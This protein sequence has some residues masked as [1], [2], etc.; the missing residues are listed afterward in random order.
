MNRKIYIG[1]ENIISPL[2]ESAESTFSSMKE[3][4]TAVRINKNRGFNNEDL[5]LSTFSKP[6]TF[7]E[8]LLQCC[9][10]FKDLLSSPTTLLVI[11]TTKGDLNHH[12]KAILT[13]VEEL[14]S[15]FNLP[16]FPLIISNACI[17]GVVAINKAA[18]LVRLGRFER[19]IVLGCDV[20]S[21]FVTYGFQC[22][23]A[24]SESPCKP[25]DK[26]RSGINLGEA[27]ASVLITSNKNE[28]LNDP[29]LWLAGATTND[30]NH[31]SGPS[32]TGEGL[33][34]AIENTCKRANIDKTKIDVI[35]AH[36][37]STRY[38]DDMESIAFNR[39]G[40][41]DVRLHSIK[42]YL[43]H[44]LGAAGVLETAIT[45]QCMR[46][47]LWL[48]TAGFDQPGTTESLNVQTQ[49]EELQVKTA[50]KSAS[51]F[52]GCNSALLLSRQ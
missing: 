5:Y 40:L 38:N 20:V 7:T 31:I 47:G 34:R 48:S 44:T 18:E 16:T 39:A 13:P 22:L 14:V 24:L 19:A 8:L 50:M 52:G 41:G 27:A 35:A 9:E 6:R 36:G 15:R 33:Y 12:S 4:E 23:Y 37:T 45:L 46:N 51:G 11:S 3:G 28:L 1:S 29:F 2:G 30:A 49:N 42:G 10:P 43:G 17:S 26:N 32:R 25:Y 21:D